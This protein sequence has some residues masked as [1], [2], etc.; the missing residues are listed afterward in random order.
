LVLTARL[1]QGTHERALELAT[2][3]PTHPSASGFTRLSVYLS[4][5]EVVFLIEAPAAE[6]LVRR[7]FDDPVRSTEISPWLPLF[8]GPLHRAYEVYHWSSPNAG[9]I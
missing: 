3:M 5:V 6:H 2:A 1:R 9:A 4:E 8:D 7:L